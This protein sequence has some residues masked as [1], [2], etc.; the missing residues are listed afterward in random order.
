MLPV[1]LAAPALLVLQADPWTD[2][3]AQLEARLKAQPGIGAVVLAERVDAHTIRLRI[4]AVGAGFKSVDAFSKEIG[5]AYEIRASTPQMMD[6][7]DTTSLMPAEATSLQVQI[8]GE[9]FAPKVVVPISRAGAKAE[10][11][12]ILMGVRTK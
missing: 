11:A 10:P 9:M 12:Y 4:K 5:G 8:S 2:A 1:L 6:S 7:F 3:V